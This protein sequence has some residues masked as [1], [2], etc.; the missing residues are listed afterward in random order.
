MYFLTKSSFV[1]TELYIKGWGTSVKMVTKY[2]SKNLRPALLEGIHSI[3][4]RKELCHNLVE[5]FGDLYS[6][7]SCLDSN[8]L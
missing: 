8:N 5:L 6:D 1:G 4:E 2:C 7:P 3:D